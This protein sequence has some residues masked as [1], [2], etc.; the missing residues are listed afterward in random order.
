M[1]TSNE[2]QNSERCDEVSPYLT[3]SCKPV[4]VTKFPE[5]LPTWGHYFIEV[6]FPPLCLLVCVWVH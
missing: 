5:Y 3:V 2:K 4:P 1:Y 6:D